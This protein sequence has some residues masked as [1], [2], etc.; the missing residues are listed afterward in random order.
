MAAARIASVDIS[1]PQ[2]Y[3]TLNAATTLNALAIGSVSYTGGGSGT[4]STSG[5]STTVTGKG[6]TAF[7]PDMSGG[8]IL[9]KDSG[10]VYRNEYITAYTSA[11]SITIGTARTISAG[12]PYTIIY[13]GLKVNYAGRLNE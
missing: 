10:G 8:T 9:F 6:T 11:T 5:S 3:S 13:D 2:G 4:I 12:T 1:V 7:T